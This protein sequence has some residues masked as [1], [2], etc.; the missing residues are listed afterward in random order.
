MTF[1]RWRRGLGTALSFAAFGL[2]GLLIGLL[3]GP[4]LWV[5][6]RDAARRK[7]VARRMISRLFRAHVWLMRAVGVMDCLVN[8][9]E[10][11]ERPGLLVVANHP[12]LID[13]VLMIAHMPNAVC[14]V[15]ERFA[16]SL[17]FRGPI[18]A[19]G[20]ITTTSPEAVIE[21][22]AAN[23]NAGYSILVFPEG[24]RSTPGRPVEF[25]RGGAN[26][27][28]RTSTNITPVVIRCE[29]STLTR[30]EPWYRIPPRK[31]QMS[32]RVLEDMPIERADRR[33]SPQ[34]A[35][36][37]TSYLTAFFNE[38]LEFDHCEREPRLAA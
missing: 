25:R 20:Y 29:P 14:I 12:T 21:A 4:I 23:L 32:I 36:E 33:P 16:K 15:S 5:C 34:R 6:I 8:N 1:D 24:T 17:V 13:T 10:R 11:L 38:E 19:A 26:L 18:W 27:A 7:R 22:A 35:R 3:A 31:V 30:G 37:L 28:L 2:G 9:P